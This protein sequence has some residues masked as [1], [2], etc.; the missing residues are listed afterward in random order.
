MVDL[1]EETALIES[2]PTVRR[3]VNR[4]ALTDGDTLFDTTAPKGKR[5]SNKNGPGTQPAYTTSDTCG[6]SCEQ[7]LLTYSDPMNGHWK[8]GCS[9][10]VLDE[11]ITA[12]CL[13]DTDNDGY[14]VKD[15]D[16]D[17]E[18]ASI[19]PAADESCDGIDNN[20][21]GRI[22]DGPDSDG[23][24]APD[25]LDGCP[26][27]P[28]K[29]EPDICGC[30]AADTD[31]DGDG[32]LDCKDSCPYDPEKTE[33]G[34]CGCGIA[35]TDSDGDGT[36]DCNDN[37]PDDPDK[38]APNICGCGIADTDSDGDGT[39]DC[40]DNCPDDP[41]KM[42][43]GVCGCGAAD[44][45]SDGDDV[46]DCEDGCPDDPVKT[47]PGICGCGEPDEDSD[48]D[49]TAECNDNCPDDPEKT[50][51]GICGCGAAD[52][53]ADEDGSLDC[54]D[55]CPHDDYHDG[56]GDPCNH[57]EDIDGFED[58][59]DACPFEPGSVNGCPALTCDGVL[60]DDSLVCSGHGECVLQDVCQ[61]EAGYE[62]PDCF[63][64]IPDSDDDGI[65]D[66]EDP[67]P[68]DPY[69]DDVGDPCN[70]DEDSDGW[71]DWNDLCP[72]EP[73]TEA[74]CP[75]IEQQVCGDGIVHPEEECDDGN[76][77]DF[78]G[79]SSAC[80][81]E[82]GCIILTEPLIFSE[83]GNI[84]YKGHGCS[85]YAGQ[86]ID[87]Y[88]FI[89]VGGEWSYTEICACPPYS[90]PTCLYFC[91]NHFM[92]DE[93]MCTYINNMCEYECITEWQCTY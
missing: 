12:F 3:G 74:G 81:K 29:I 13:A 34:L 57:D 66:F 54:Q 72:F 60:A 32:T 44:A 23:D 49:G 52:A 17:D 76:L 22:D 55:P 16:C 5:K 64:E 79:C 92:T 24:G 21:N 86:R 45:D 42:L 80:L 78:D 87:G 30:G 84:L 90:C 31:S 20:C 40:N 63:D 53:D 18:D 35:D 65:P 59:F 50:A 46:M 67:C 77:D 28:G 39:A 70:H 56:V 58:T 7:I 83:G 69:H 15:G 6:C 89:P 48:G 43:P 33:P 85:S 11:F 41:D 25:C 9:S 38:T 37:C 93:E 75:V 27:D 61:C 10:G 91:G 73:G 19:H 51:P 2:V 36:V 1:C 4:F 62:G 26:D 82:C 71:N 8:F 88:G 47:E 14:S 68:H